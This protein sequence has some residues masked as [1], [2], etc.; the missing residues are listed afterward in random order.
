ML[1]CRREDYS[2]VTPKF[3]RKSLFLAVLLV[4]SFFM[5]VRPVRAALCALD[6]APAAT[7]LVPYFEVDMTRQSCQRGT[8]VSTTVFV[9]NLSASSVLAHVVLWSAWSVPVLDFDV[10]I[11]GYG[12]QEIDLGEILCSGEIPGAESAN[13]FKGREVS[14]E[15][16]AHMV[17]WLQ[18]KESP[19]DQNCAGPAS[20]NKAIG[21]V[22]I[23]AV[24]SSTS[25]SPADGASYMAKLDT[26]NVMVGDAYLTDSNVRGVNSICAGSSRCASRLKRRVLRERGLPGLNVVHIE[27]DG[28]GTLFLNGDTT[29]YG[30]YTNNS[31][32][33]KREPLP[34]VYHIRYRK[35]VVKK[36]L[37]MITWREGSADASPVDCGTTPSWYPLDEGS[38]IAFNDDA[39]ALSIEE[40]GLFKD[41][42]GKRG[43]LPSKLPFDQGW[44]YVYFGNSTNPDRQAYVALQRDGAIDDTGVFPTSSNC[45]RLQYVRN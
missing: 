45:P 39:E 33:D 13:G 30:R 8:G 19:R 20:G 11:K 3:A 22:T 27:A 41:E 24:T 38:R 18:G 36:K 4:C 16:R 42:A 21:Y 40:L 32:A 5:Q 2:L 1:G 12:V 26:R 14:E 35:T 29:F 6:A 10:Y 17:A 9:T 28:S 43:N 7:L 25:G 31:A 23:D 44:L 37:D 15:T 34:S